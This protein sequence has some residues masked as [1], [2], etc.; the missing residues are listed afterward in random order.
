[1]STEPTNHPDAVCSRYGLPCHHDEM[2]PDFRCTSCG[3]ELV[4]LPFALAGA[5]AR[6]NNHPRGSNPFQAGTHE[7]FSWDCGWEEEDA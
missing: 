1:M 3:K 7:H 6:E 5:R 2:S 4:L